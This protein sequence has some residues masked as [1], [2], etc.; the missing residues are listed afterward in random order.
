MTKSKLRTN[1]TVGLTK[2]LW[3]SAW[4]GTLFIIALL[5]IAPGVSAQEQPIQPCV[6]KKP[7]TIEPNAPV[8]TNPATRRT[9]SRRRAPAKKRKPAAKPSPA[10]EQ[11]NIV[12]SRASETL[13]DSS[14]PKDLSV[15]R[16][17]EPYSAKV[18]ALEVVIGKLEG[19]L[20]KGPLGAGS[21][22]NFVAD[23]I[24]AQASALLG[25][26]VLLAVTNSGG[27]RKNIIAPGDLRAMD[28]FELLPFENALI[29]MDLTGEQLL[30]LLSVVTAGRDAQSGAR[31]KYRLNE[32]NNRPELV[33]AVLVDGEGRET[34]IDPKATYRI[35][36]IDYLLKLASGSY[37]I[38]Q[39]G[40]NVKPLGVTIRD[41]IMDYVKAETTASRTIKP[42]LDDRFVLIKTNGSTAEAKPQ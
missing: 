1:K 16:M 9:S 15:E 4:P 29:E 25:R 42:K 3:R 40:K 32:E 11:A 34:T 12:E 27:L 5:A 20:S 30:R 6:E 22:G 21:L 24:R 18:R 7:C 33:S 38:L 23:G 2:F 28:I 35:V 17:L 19:E 10:N 39:E 13:I 36:T 37:S 31:V 41:A 26:P 8:K 14:I